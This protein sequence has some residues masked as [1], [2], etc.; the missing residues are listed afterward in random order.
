MD[1]AQKMD[2]FQKF[3]WF[4][5]KKVHFLLDFLSIMY[6]IK[7]NEMREVPQTQTGGEDD[8]RANFR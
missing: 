7:D 2:V 4:F 6:Y 5:P 1:Y 3:F 8:D